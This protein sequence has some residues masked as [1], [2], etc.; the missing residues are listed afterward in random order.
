[1]KLRNSIIAISAAL[2]AASLSACGV[3]EA[4]STIEES[5]LATPLP[6]EVVLAR[7]AE[8]FATYRTTSNIS[9]D[10]DAAV[11]ARVGGDVTEILVEEGDQVVQGQVL[12]RLDGER[13][14]L[15]MQQARANLDKTTREYE[16]FINLHDR[17]LVSSAAFDSM[18]YDLDSLRASYELKRLYYNYTFIRAPIS[19]VISS[20]DIKVGQQI[21]AGLSTFRV[22]DTSALVAYLHIPQSELGKFSPGIFADV[23][24]D[25]MPEEIFQASIARV[26]PTIDVRNGTFRVTAYINNDAGLL[27]PGMFGRFA[28]AYERHSDA[29]LI[30]A[31]AVLQEDNQSVVYVVDNGAAVRRPIQTGIVEDGHVEVLSGLDG[32]EDIIVTGQNG[33]RDGS[34]VLA[35]VPARKPV[36][37]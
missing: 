12:A 34:R 16:R 22:T 4:R 32:S 5:E 36:N 28:I 35:S 23:Q 7:R 15:E 11:T 10:V 26:S 33:L 21:G 20:R 3:G 18:K 24:V 27:A 37:G 2:L 6:V 1:M 13:L 14:R 31:A 19:G 17:G 8:I 30:P 29:L 9:S 25:A